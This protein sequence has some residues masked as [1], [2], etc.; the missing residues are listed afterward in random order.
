M[1]IL[2]I[3]NIQ[4]RVLLPNLFQKNG[5]L[6]LLIIKIEEK[7]NYIG[8][9]AQNIDTNGKSQTFDEDKI[10]SEDI[11]V[12]WEDMDR[13]IKGDGTILAHAQHFK[14]KKYLEVDFLITE[15]SL[16]SKIFSRMRARKRKNDS[17]DSLM[18]NLQQKLKSKR[19]LILP[20]QCPK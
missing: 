12:K 7:N 1:I 19:E 5:F 8:I 18:K 20:P 17:K 6:L 15:G 3:C 14:N 11:H 16:L 9:L 2:H 4:C 10:P 13:H